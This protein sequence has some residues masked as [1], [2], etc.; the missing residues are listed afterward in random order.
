MNL[1][2]VP[3]LDLITFGKTGLDIG[4]LVTLDALAGNRAARER[5]PALIKAIE[6]TASPQLR[7]SGTIGGNLAQGSRCW[8]F[9]GQF[10]CW[11]K[12]G[13]LCYA[14][15]GENSHHAIFGGG[16]CYMVHPSDLAPVLIALGA[17]VR[18]TGIRGERIMPVEELFQLPHEDGR[19]L[20]VL[21]PG[22]IITGVHLPVPVSGSSGTYLKAMERK[23]WAFA[24][25]S[26]ALQLVVQDNVIKDSRVVL[27]GVAPKPW[28]LPEVEAFLHDRNIGPAVIGQA[29]DMAVVGAQPLRGNNY[30]IALVKGIMREAL[31]SILGHS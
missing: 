3:G 25:T 7:N 26:V 15:E 8:Y 20:T 14:R 22:E 11:L 12:Q 23:V 24:L 18:T 19:Q 4:A 13:E 31:S 21:E 16:P 1:K 9:R 30:K 10:H 6:V 28:R 5:Y 17:E 27:G 2:T 29:A